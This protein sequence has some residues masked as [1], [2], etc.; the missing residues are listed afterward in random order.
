MKKQDKDFDNLVTKVHEKIANE[1]ITKH[2][3]QT[4]LGILVKLNKNK[5][6]DILNYS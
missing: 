3:S 4:L 1:I 2:Y 6:S 5:L